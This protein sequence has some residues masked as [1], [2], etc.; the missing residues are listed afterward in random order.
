MI[1]QRQEQLVEITAPA[2]AP[3]LAASRNEATELRNLIRDSRQ[4]IA[5][6]FSQTLRLYRTAAEERHRIHQIRTSI[7]DNRH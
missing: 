7:E 1:Q 6:D 3:E 5:S 2:E 4:D